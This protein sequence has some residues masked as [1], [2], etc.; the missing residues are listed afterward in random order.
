[1]SL[2]NLRAAF[3]ALFLVLIATP[4]AAQSGGSISNPR[5]LT[6]QTIHD[7][8]GYTPAQPG[9]NNDITSLNALTGTNL[10]PSYPPLP[11]EAGPIVSTIYPAGDFRRYAGPTWNDGV[12]DWDAGVFDTWAANANLPGVLAYLPPAYY[13]NGHTLR[14]V[15]SGARF[16]FAD[17]AELAAI[18]HQIASGTQGQ[19]TC[20]LS[21]GAVNAVT[22][23]VKGAGYF[24]PPKVFAYASSGGNTISGVTL[25]ATMEADA[26]DTYVVRG[27]G[28]AASDTITLQNG[29]VVTVGAVT[30][31]G[32]ISTVSITTRGTIADPSAG[33]MANRYVQQ[34]TSGAGTG[35]QFLIGFRVASL[36]I[37]SGGTG[38]A[39]TCGLFIDPPY[40][41]D[42]R[43]S[44][45]ITS[46][47]RLGVQGTVD[48]YIKA[49]HG[50]SDTTKSTDG[51][52]N[53]GAHIDYN[54]N[55]RFGE[56]EVD[57]AGDASGHTGWAAVSIDGT[58]W[59]QARATRGERIHVKA[60]DNVGVAICGEAYVDEVRVA[61]FGRG[62]SVTSTQY[63]G[64]TANQGAGLYLYRATGRIGVARIDQNDQ[65]IGAVAQYHVL[66]A[67]TGV[68]NGG[69][70]TP[71]FNPDDNLSTLAQFNNRG[72][73]FGDLMLTNVSRRGGLAIQDRNVTDSSGGADVS[74]AGRLHV[75]FSNAIAMTS[76]YQGVAV[77][78]PQST[79][80]G[81]RS[82]LNAGT[83]LFLNSGTPAVQPDLFLADTGSDVSWGMMRIPYHGGGSLV[84]IKGRARGVIDMD[85][86]ANAGLPTT[87][88]NTAVLLSGTDT[89]GSDLRIFADSGNNQMVQQVLKLDGT[90]SVRVGGYINHYRTMNIVELANTNT[91]PHLID[92]HVEG[93]AAGQTG[94]G[95]YL[96]GTLTRP[97]LR[98]IYIKNFAIGAAKNGSPTIT[99]GVLDNC[100][101]ETNAT[102][103]SNIPNGSFT[104]LTQAN[105][106]CTL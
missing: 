31:G 74:V 77:N 56:I 63:C 71:L 47:A 80:A 42:V 13:H 4:L 52:R 79:S 27:T 94:N 70:A 25:T 49:F 98:D 30:A 35:A 24:H 1:M 67:S 46:Y 90:S 72:F 48:N 20:T 66:V 84:T 58:S 50:K 75:Q 78:A 64:T 7:A 51:T 29:V 99:N 62:A 101:S 89:A 12:T 18:W 8:L 32:M 104:M 37:G 73:A 85:M 83:I 43:V 96:G 19:G 60:A 21:G 17:G 2:R 39:G 45:L 44:G 82:M 41:K 14:A 3:A 40:L 34:S 102:A 97:V 87:S 54:D 88:S 23:T 59:R 65:K 6:S 10:P 36:A 26:I 106:G 76:T 53:P 100:T 105:S 5:P 81:L 57:D 9:A 38:G 16:N 11:G 28:Y 33:T 22:L 15:N 69:P 103:N 92:L 61:S 68:Q 95:L 93:Y 91:D 86:V 55:F